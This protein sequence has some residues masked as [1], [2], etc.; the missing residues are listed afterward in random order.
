LIF[1]GRRTWPTVNEVLA[2]ITAANNDGV[3]VTFDTF[4]YTG[5]NTTIRVI[6]PAWSQNRMVELLHS[7]DGWARLRDSF[8]PLSPFIAE[9]AQLMWA[10]NP[11][12]AHL[13]GKFF[14]EIA[15][16]LKLDPV[17]AYL[18]IARESAAKARVMMHLYSGDDQHEETLC[19]AMAH[20]LNMFEMDTILTSHQHQNPASF[21]TYPKILGH[22][23]REMGLLSLES[24]IHKMTGMAAAKMRLGGRG[25]IREGYAADL[26]IFNPATISC[27]ADFAHPETA[28]VG[29]EHVLVNGRAVVAD[30]KWCG[31]GVLPGHWL[32]RA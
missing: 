27:A 30:G 12:F 18:T 28:P 14:G 32:T 20:P 7:A 8:R 10:A 29:I 13:E 5:G 24:A 22:Y 25:F 19:A 4:P 1:V 17:E 26:A 16:S 11:S 15:E 6:F 3:D 2:D 21:G 31:D 23:V 9:G